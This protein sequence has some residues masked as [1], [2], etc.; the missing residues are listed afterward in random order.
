MRT[1][2]RRSTAGVLALAALILLSIPSALQAR[3]EP[4]ISVVDLKGSTFQISDLMEGKPTLLVFWVRASSTLWRKA[5]AWR[6]LKRLEILSN[7][8]DDFFWV[9][10]F[11]AQTALA[12]ISASACSKSDSCK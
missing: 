10:N 6:L 2:N 12:K 8:S 3:P 11:A 9:T 1:M 5:F 4:S 7:S